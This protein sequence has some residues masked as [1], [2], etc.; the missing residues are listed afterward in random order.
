[1]K[2]LKRF[3]A[4]MTALLIFPVCFGTKEAK[5]AEEKVELRVCNWGEYVSNGEDGC[6]DVLKEFESRFPNID[7]QYTTYATNEEIYAKLTSGSANYDVI[8]PSDYMISRMIQEDMLQKINFDNIPNFS[9]VMDEFKNLEYDPT[10]EYSVPYTWGTVGIIY[11]TTMVEEEVTS[12][13]ALW[14]P[15][16]TNNI[17]MFDNSRDA[18]GIALKKLGYSQ[19]TADPARLEEAAEELIKQKEVLQ[20]YVMDE[21]FDKMSSG[22]AA[23]APYYAGDGLI[24]IEDNPD[25]AFVVPEEGTNRFVDAMVIPKGARE[26]EA[27]ET[28]INF[29]LETDIAMAN[30]EYLGY[31]TPQKSVYEQL[32]EE[33]INDGISYPSEEVLEKCD[34]FINLP[35]ETN[36]YMQDLWLDVKASGSSSVFEL[37]FLFAVILGLGAVTIVYLRR[38]KRQI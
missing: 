30:I 3:A 18:F 1:M 34:T 36:A 35:D 37:L 22:E 25:L 13:E 24:M 27:A 21:I 6:L 31:S 17:L 14:D 2:K 4:L 8:F 29:M 9:D 11:N 28:F 12:W 38:R 32:D 10:N 16:Y 33:V 5:A 7:L 20:S 15:K 23:L 26:K 19:N